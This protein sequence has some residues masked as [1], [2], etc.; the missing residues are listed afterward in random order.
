MPNCGRAPFHHC[1]MPRNG[2]LLARYHLEFDGDV[3]LWDHSLGWWYD[4]PRIFS[5]LGQNF[6]ALHA[7]PFAGKFPCPSISRNC[8]FFYVD[9][10]DSTAPNLDFC[11][12]GVG[13]PSMEAWTIAI[14]GSRN[15]IFSHHLF[16][17][18][19]LYGYF[20]TFAFVRTFEFRFDFYVRILMD[21][22]YYAVAISFFKI[23]F[24]HA[25]TI[26]GW[27]EPQMM[28]F[29]SAYIMVDALVMTLFVNGLWQFPLLV[30]RGDL[31]YHLIRPVSSL[32]LLSL[33]D[34]SA[35]S[36]VNLLITG[37][38]MAWSIFHCPGEFSPLRTF[39]YLF[40]VFNG[41]VIFFSLYLLAN[42][43]VVFT[44]SPDGFGQLIWGLTKLSERPDQI[45]SGWTRRI[46]TSV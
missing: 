4:P 22:F 40:L 32:F 43:P 30:N 29:V 28:V 42:L 13:L 35:S 21:V 31:D 3:A 44:Q 14:H 16:R 2:G 37:S 9:P 11:L 15:M 27:T 41:S 6:S 7:L 33:R 20:L 36:F 46:F 45:F 1:R 17:Y 18:P 19:R 8:F 26:G 12:S 38:I 25:P 5:H 39:L 34:F 24:L 10:P 23:L